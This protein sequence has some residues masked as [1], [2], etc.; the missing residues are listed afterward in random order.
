[1][2]YTDGC[3]D[4]LQCPSPPLTLSVMCQPYQPIFLQSYMIQFALTM[5]SQRSLKLYTI[6]IL[7]S[8][9]H[10]G[11]RCSPF[12]LCILLMVKGATW[13]YSLSRN[14]VCFSSFEQNMHR[15]QSWK[16]THKGHTHR[17]SMPML[18]SRARDER[19][20]ER[21]LSIARLPLASKLL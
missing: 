13:W 7:K 4:T 15:I 19:G 8:I 6:C 16:T 11:N 18:T 12:S 2:R 20:E 21:T 9:P 17:Q 5:S 3:Q 14:N 10:T 1:M